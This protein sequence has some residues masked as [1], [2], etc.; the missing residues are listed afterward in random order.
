MEVFEAVK[1]YI[2]P[3]LL[4][5]AIV[6]Y[7]LGIGIRNTEKIDN[8]YI[9]LILGIFGILISALYVIATSTFNG[10]QSVL[11]AI[12]T[13]IVQGILVAGVSVYVNQLIK[14][15]NKEE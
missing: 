10:Y 9:P 11:M 4:V 3:E 8:K 2:K 7:F 14:Q 12:F 15:T 1:D 13:S 5:V 6:L